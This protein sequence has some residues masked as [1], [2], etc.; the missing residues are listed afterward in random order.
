MRTAVQ[1]RP[2]AR[3]AAPRTTV[4]FDLAE[5]ARRALSVGEAMDPVGDEAA[6]SH[7]PGLVV[8]DAHGG[9]ESCT[10]GTERWLAEL[11]DGDAVAGLLPSSLRALAGRV[12][13]L[14]EDPA[15]PAG[16]ALSWVP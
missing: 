12:L 14:A 1:S 15:R 13:R 4:A 8:L 2:L 10:P 9:L 5:G 6:G 3:T 16:L 7:P 11:P